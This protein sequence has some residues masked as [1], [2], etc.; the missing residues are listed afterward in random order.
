MSLVNILT[1]LVLIPPHLSLARLLPPR[2][3]LRRR[4][5]PCTPYLVRTKHAVRSLQPVTIVAYMAPSH[6][7]ASL[8][9][10]CREAQLRATTCLSWPPAFSGLRI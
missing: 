3:D 9:A 1:M 6:A 2:S 5:A 10:T 8:A 4:L 7:P